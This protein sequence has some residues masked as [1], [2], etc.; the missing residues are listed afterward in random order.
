MMALLGSDVETQIIALR[1]Q[2][3]GDAIQLQLVRLFITTFIRSMGSAY[4]DYR[5]SM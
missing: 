5:S 4:R 3:C 2:P 1:V